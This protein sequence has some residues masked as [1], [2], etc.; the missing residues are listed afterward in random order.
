ME[1]SEVAVHTCRRDTIVIVRIG[2]HIKC[3][4]LS[5]YIYI[6]FL[7]GALVSDEF[8]HVR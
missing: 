3:F 7:I 5:N 2:H 1:V 6:Y 8:I 4:Q